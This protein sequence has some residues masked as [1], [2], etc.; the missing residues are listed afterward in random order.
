MAKN[1]N[2]PGKLQAQHKAQATKQKF[3]NVV[4]ANCTSRTKRNLTNILSSVTCEFFPVCFCN[5]APKPRFWID[6]TCKFPCVSLKVW[7]FPRIFFVMVR[8]ND[9]NLPTPIFWVLFFTYTCTQKHFL[10]SNTYTEYA[11]RK[12]PVVNSLDIWIKKTY[13][14][15]MMI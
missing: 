6:A 10:C 1:L 4:P 15:V 7:V 2:Q 13:S 5:F 8:Q 12:K 14:Y 11:I 9:K 3:L